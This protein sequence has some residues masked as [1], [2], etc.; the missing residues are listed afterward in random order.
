MNQKFTIDDFPV[1]EVVEVLRSCEFTP[2]GRAMLVAHASA[3]NR[4]LSRL[5]LAKAIGKSSVNSCNSTYGRLAKELVDAIDPTVS[6]RSIEKFGRRIDF[7]M[8]LNT[9]PARWTAT[10]KDEPDTWVFVMRETLARALDAVGMATYRSL[11]ADAEAAIDAWLGNEP[12]DDRTDDPLRD[13]E[14]AKEQLNAVDRTVRD[15]LIQARLGQGCFRDQLLEYWDG[16]CAL[17][18]V[19]IVEALVA[20]HIKPWRDANNA[21][22]LDPYNGLLLVG[23]VDRLFDKGLVGFDG[24]GRMIVKGEL[25]DDDLSALGLERDM[26]L[27]HVHARHKQYLAEHRRIHGL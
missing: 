11:D 8:F 17:T 16:R 23:T 26:R 2:N 5:E 6:E 12:G 13:I 3:K 25:T 21:E 9:G 1:S 19:S 4:A 18:G 24:R 7:V 22:R 20:S 14:A 27:D 15:Q 10:P